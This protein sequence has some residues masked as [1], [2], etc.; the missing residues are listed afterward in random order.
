MNENEMEYRGSKSLFNF[1]NVKE[2]R[3]NGSWYINP[4][5][6]YLRYT[7]TDF[8]R[9]YQINNPSKQ[10]INKR[11]FSTVNTQ[12]KMN[13]WFVTGL[14]EAEGSFIT[15]ISKNNKNKRTKIGW[16]V[17]SNL[18]ITLHQRDLSLLI[19][20][21]QFFGGIGRIYKDSNYKNVKYVVTKLSDLIN[22]IIPHFEKYP[23]LTQKAADFILFQRVINI[24]STKDHL[25]IEGLYK[26]INIKASINL[27]LSDELKS[28]FINCTPVERPKNLTKYIP[29]PNWI[30]GFVE[31][32]GNFDINIHKSKSNKILYQIQLRF[33]I[34]QH[35]RDLKL[36]E[37]LIKY[38]GTGIIEKNTKTG[39][40]SLTITKFSSI[41]KI[42]IPFFEKISFDWCKTIRLS[43]LM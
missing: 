38:L 34:S 22:V 10:L 41:T 27:G 35:E 32:E 28:N 30:S 25:S 12:P 16:V 26:I 20:L 15:R 1:N 21:Q 33:R 7:L 40:V 8:E 18:Q 31:G 37:L 17:S 14:L 42:I 9:N 19:M 5:L 3:V 4:N 29:D 6:M 24:I 39:V 11:T 43:R 2:Q 36:M 13:P 23:L